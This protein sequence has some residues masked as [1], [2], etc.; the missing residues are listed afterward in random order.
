MFARTD[1]NGRNVD[2]LRDLPGQIRNHNLEHDR[3][4]AR[5]LYRARIGQQC[6]GF[7]LRAPFYFI[8]AFFA[9]ALRQHPDVRHK[10][11]TCTRDRFDLTYPACAALQLHP[12]RTGRDKLS[13][14]LQP[15]L[16]CVVGVNRHVGDEQCPLHSARDRTRVMQHLV[17]RDRR[18]IFIPKDDHPDRIAHQNDIDPAFIQQPGGRI[19]VSRQRGDFFTAAFHL[20]KLLDQTGHYHF[21]IRHSTLADSSSSASNSRTVAVCFGKTSSGRISASGRNTN[22]LKCMRGWGNC[23]RSLLILRRPQ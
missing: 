5:F 9:H 2:R 17:E 20:A 18:R 19:I 4:R 23:N 7:G 22:F 14:R 21:S 15:L 10:W 8:A 16:R 3:E 6:L 1:A 13:R 12:M 11:N